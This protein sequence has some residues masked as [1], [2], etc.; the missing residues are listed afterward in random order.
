MIKFEKIEVPKNGQK[1]EIKNYKL[2]I[3]D[4]PIIPFIEGDGIGSDIMKVTRKVIDAAV[5]KAYKGKKKIIW[6]E[7]FAG[8]KAQ[9]IYGKVLPEDT[10]KAIENFIVA[11]K[12][13]LTTP[14]GGG[15]RSLNVALRQ[16]FDLYSCIRPVR[17]FNGVP[18]PVKHPERMN[19]VIF[20]ENTEDVYAGIEWKEGTPEVKKIIDF[21]KNTYKIDIPSDSGIGIKPISIKRTERLVRAAVK[22][23]INKKLNRV[24]IVHKGNV[25]KYTEGS[26]RDWGYKLARREFKDLIITE[27][28]LWEKFNGNIP[29]E[30]ILINDRIADSMFQQILTRTNE[31]QVIAT[32]NLNGDYLSDA[33]AAQ[34]G[35]LG[36]AP[37]ANI[38]DYIGLFEATHG[39][40]PK[41]TGQD[42]VNPSS[43]ILS[44]VM[45]LEYMGWDKASEIII[46]A[47]QKTIKQKKV[48]Y[49]LARLMENVEP[50]KCSE[51]GNAI[52]KNMEFKN[53]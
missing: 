42:K 6:F 10:F 51:Y 45:M 18:S 12:G 27:D 15:Y 17:Y 14:V 7:I 21:I 3:P 8:E 52:I 13:P 24:T 1:I 40:A 30:K 28:E 46:N 36:M 43:L 20:R 19:M 49:D 31:Y 22:Y 41:Y 26:F 29:E 50:I 11:I 47:V 48:T 34:I 23:A 38:G 37:G 33:A 16:K 9:K 5:D 4:N 35:G 32:P 39:S 44:G 25:M 53:L 2:I